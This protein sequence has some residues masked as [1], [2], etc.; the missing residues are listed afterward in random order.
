MFDLFVLGVAVCN[1]MQADKRLATFAKAIRLGTLC[2][3]VARLANVVRDV[4]PIGFRE[5][6]PRGRRCANRCE[7]SFRRRP[8]VLCRVS[9]F[10]R[11]WAGHVEMQAQL[12][13]AVPVQLGGSNRL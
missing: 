2:G 11:R 3:E 1:G 6:G 13:G 10:D 4:S 12:V 8:L 9:D 7:R 5:G